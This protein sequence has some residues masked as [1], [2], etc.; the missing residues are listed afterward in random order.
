MLPNNGTIYL[1][2]PILGNTNVGK[3]T[4]FHFFRRQTTKQ[5]SYKNNDFVLLENIHYKNQIFNIQF[6]D[7]FGAKN[8]KQASRDLFLGSSVGIV[9]YDI[10]DMSKKSYNDVKN[11]I[12]RFWNENDGITKPIL[13]LGNKLDLRKRNIKTL[14]LTDCSDIA[15]LLSKES[16]LKIPQFEISALTRENCNEIMEIIMDLAIQFNQNPIQSNI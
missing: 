7:S 2:V 14:Y 5:F 10:S 11:W 15:D 12:Y 1:K 8:F 6:W 13:I 3:T 4:L 16:N 9:L